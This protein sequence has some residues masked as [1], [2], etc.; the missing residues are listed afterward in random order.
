MP[1]RVIAVSGLK[2][3]IG[4]ST[5][6]MF[7]AFVWAVLRGKRVLY[8]DADPSSQTGWDW[9]KLARDRDT[10]LPF[11]I[12]TW[13]HAQVGDMVADRTP[14][15]YDVVVI[16]CGGDSD[17][18]LRSAVEVCTYALVVT[19]PNKADIRRLSATF[20]SALKAAKDAGRTSEIDAAVVFTK[21]D[22]R[23]QAANKEMRRQIEAKLPML[24]RELSLKPAVYADAM[25]TNVTS[26]ADLE[27]A[28]ELVEEMEAAA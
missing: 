23:R 11:D 8:V 24:Q 26:H 15:K 25:G 21:V 12:E 3:G 6:A 1:D 2:G 13:P 28:K 14:G 10:P 17:A 18:I 20:A 9:W 4:K 22:N 16:D 27:E 7:I 5:L 19:T